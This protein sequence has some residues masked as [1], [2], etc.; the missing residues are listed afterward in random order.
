MKKYNSCVWYILLLGWAQA[1][2]QTAPRNFVFFSQEREGIHDSTFYRHPAVAGAQITYPWKQLEPQPGEYDFRAVEED[3]RFLE[4]QGKR[5]FIQLQ[6]V[7]FD[8]QYYAVPMYLRTD[9]A[10]HGGVNSQYEFAEGREDQAHKAGWV[11]RRW[12]PAVAARFHRLLA[13]L[14]QAFDGR[15]EGINLP[16]SAVEFGDSGRWYPPGFT[17]ATYRDAIRENMRVLK[18]AF[19]KSVT[20]QYANFMPGEWLPHNDQ[21]YLKS[22]YAYAR[23]IQCGMGGPDL[24]V[25]QRYQMKHSYPLLRD[26]QG[27]APTGL[28][29]QDGN[30]GHKNP[31]T[32]QPV[33]VQDIYEFGKTYLQLGYIFWCREEPFYTR[34][35]LP[36]LKALP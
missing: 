31:Q 27:L 13:A 30:Y 18:Q 24:K 9:T 26:L 4:A 14:G 2:A 8:S 34:D 32:G 33:T 29:V 12:D 15:I 16:E 19:P 10:Y 6:D 11:S 3:L 20:I 5:L 28:A 35:V 25:Y 21:G 1:A 22:L 17:C 23:E 36:F 7:T